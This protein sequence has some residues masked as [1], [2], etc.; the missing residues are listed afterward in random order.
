MESSYLSQL[1]SW[2]FFAILTDSKSPFDHAA[3]VSWL[4]RSAISIQSLGSRN[5]Q[6]I[7]KPC[8]DLA[9]TGHVQVEHGQASD[10]LSP[11]YAQRSR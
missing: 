5:R 6:S 7:G 10:V 3:N 1:E 4:V 11:I 2:L 8:F 9:I